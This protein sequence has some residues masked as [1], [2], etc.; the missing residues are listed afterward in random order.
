MSTPL[1]PMATMS[2]EQNAK[3]AAAA[4]DARSRAPQHATPRVPTTTMRRRRQSATATKFARCDQLQWVWTACHCHQRQRARGGQSGIAPT[5]VPAPRRSSRRRWSS[6]ERCE[7]VAKRGCRERRDR[8]GRERGVEV[9]G[10]SWPIRLLS[11]RS[12][13]RYPNFDL[14]RSLTQRN[15]DA[16]VLLSFCPYHTR[17]RGPRAATQGST[18]AHAPTVRSSLGK[19]GIAEAMGA[20]SGTTGRSGLG[21]M[22]L[23]SG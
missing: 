10:E 14:L 8:S 15:P 13:Q 2:M 21:S 6:A 3:A 1:M 23:S 19:S 22:P 5:E 20:G 11:S 9:G 17:H 16:P 4:L 12:F 18:R 7:G